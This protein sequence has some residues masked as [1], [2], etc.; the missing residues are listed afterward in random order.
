[1]RCAMFLL[2]CS[3]F[4]TAATYYVDPGGSDGNPGSMAQ[5]WA[6]VSHAVA[7][8]QP[9][10]VI[11]LRDGAY[12]P[13][14]HTSGFPVRIAKAG[15]PAA[16]IVVKAEHKWGAVLDCASP[17]TPCSGY[18]YLD[19]GAAYWVFQDLIFQH[20]SNFGMS[21][22]SSPAAHDI[23]VHGCRF[24]YIGQRANDSVYGEAGVYV[25]EGSSN[26]TF[27]GNVFHD[28]G[29]TSGKYPSNDHG[30]YLHVSGAA[31]VNN[32]FYAPISGWALQTADG[33]SGL[34][35]LN[36]FA[37][38][39]QNNGG[40][41]MLWG[42]N[43]SLT[44]RDNIFYDPAGAIAIN[45]SALDIA[46]GCSVD[47]NLVTGGTAGFAPGCASSD[48]ILADAGLVDAMTQ[49]YDFHLLPDSPAIDA[50]V[51][52]P[53]VTADFDG[54]LRPQGAAPDIGAYEFPSSVPPAANRRTPL[55][56]K[57]GTTQQLLNRREKLQLR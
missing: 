39:M 50:G 21:A 44:I 9:G 19:T 34:I 29:R 23:L 46:G 42:A 1:M 27:D 56:P 26:F 12:G 49:P 18:I 24:E 28:I 32:I 51:P 10:D 40:H 33:F 53:S 7:A 35:A 31:V 20:G 17:T 48:N 38:P 43:S 22:N 4:M 14:G 54:A 2:A 25:G 52:V 16:W 55:P 13:E 45:T 15:S 30:L 37:F 41:I 3:R 47:H 36:T 6:T 11:V 8:A 57:S 5:P